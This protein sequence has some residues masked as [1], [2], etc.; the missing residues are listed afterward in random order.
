MVG[1]GKRSLFRH[2]RLLSIGSRVRRFQEFH[3]FGSKA[4]PIVSAAVFAPRH[5]ASR[6]ERSAR[7]ASASSQQHF[8]PY[9]PGGVTVTVGG[10]TLDVWW[11]SRSRLTGD[12]PG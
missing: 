12:G 1:T 2:L 3:K 8:Y 4:V 5:F 10:A 7:K 9:A 11:I 6:N